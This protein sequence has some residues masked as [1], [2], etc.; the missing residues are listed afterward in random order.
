MQARYRLT[1]GETARFPVGNIELGYLLPAQERSNAD[2]YRARRFFLVP[3]R[4]K[5]SYRLLHLAAE[6]G[7]VPLHLASPTISWPQRNFCRLRIPA[8]LPCLCPRP[9]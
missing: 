2:A 4:E 9:E 8:E 6:L 5:G 1:K 7:S 3:M